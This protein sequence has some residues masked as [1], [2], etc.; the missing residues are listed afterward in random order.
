MIVDY[1]T[2]GRI[3]LF[4]KGYGYVIDD[5]S[6]MYFA[7]ES[8]FWNRLMSTLLEVDSSTKWYYDEEK[9]LYYFFIPYESIRDKCPKT[10]KKVEDYVIK[11][12]RNY[13]KN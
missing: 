6:L 3:I 10:W 12:I 7:C 13:N 8:P 4:M 5:K 9:Q 1:S 11:R 2:D